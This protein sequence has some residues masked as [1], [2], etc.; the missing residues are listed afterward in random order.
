MERLSVLMVAALCLAGVTAQ[1]ST[2]LLGPGVNNGSFEEPY[3]GGV[4]GAYVQQVPPSWKRSDDPDIIIQVH[5]GA[6]H[7]VASDGAQ[8]MVAG[9]GGV[10]ANQGL[11]QDEETLGYFQANTVYTLTG[12][13][14]WTGLNQTGIPELQMRLGTSTAAE[15]AYVSSLP[16]DAPV[17]TF[18]AFP[19]I[20]VDTSV[21]L[22]LVGSPIV[23]MLYTNAVDPYPRFDHFALTATAVPEPMALALLGLG[24]LLP[25][26][27]RRR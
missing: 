2:D 22:G 20:T 7:E 17:F 21:D 11:Y 27:R 3:L 10:G 23:V 8:F 19:T 16:A 18:T 14:A 9:V 13:G 6:F 1:A 5:G 4:D 26:L 12:Y 24:G 25:V 15:G